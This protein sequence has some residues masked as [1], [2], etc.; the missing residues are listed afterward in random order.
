MGNRWRAH[1]VS[2]PIVLGMPFAAASAVPYASAWA[3]PEAAEDERHQAEGNELL[4]R[5]DARQA[6]GDHAE[7]ARAYAGAFDAFAR[8]SRSDAKEKQAVSLAIDE[9]GLAQRADPR[10]LSLLEEE[11]A[12][13][14]RFMAHPELE[15]ALQEGVT[16]ELARVR[17]RIAALKQEQAAA[18]LRRRREAAPEPDVPDR[19]ARRESL[20]ILGSGVV[21]ML[22]GAALLGAG[23]WMLGTVDPEERAMATGLTAGGAMLAGVGIGLVSWGGARLR[24]GSRAPKRR[25]S[26][27]L[28]MISVA[29]VGLVARVTF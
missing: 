7:A 10:C 24:R 20:A 27:V 19:R 6:A 1:V 4:A 13:L 18:E 3:S 5:G 29:G 23:V 25:T 12:L 16:E 22:G 14:E 2:M 9:F 15:G 8:R 28:P 11:E 26:V 21:G 17:A